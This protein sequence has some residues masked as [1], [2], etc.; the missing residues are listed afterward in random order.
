VPL[1]W[2]LSARE[3]AV[4]LAD[5]ATPLLIA[6][7]AH[8][9][10]AAELVAGSSSALSLIRVED[11]YEPWIAAHPALDPGLTVSASKRQRSDT[12]RPLRD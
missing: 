11:E 10:L 1:S 4:I 5:A 9:E 8:A 2:R 12:P 3:L 6:D 7:A